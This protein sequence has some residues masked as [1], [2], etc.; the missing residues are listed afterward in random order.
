[1]V[2]HKQVPTWQGKKNA[3]IEK[4]R[5][6]G[7]IPRKEFMAFHCLSPFQEKKSFFSL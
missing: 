2:S 7:S 5:N 4:K 1:M 3:L 6:L